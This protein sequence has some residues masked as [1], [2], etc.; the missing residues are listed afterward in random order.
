ME[1]NKKAFYAVTFSGHTFEIVV[2]DDKKM[3]IDDPKIGEKKVFYRITLNPRFVCLI[4]KDGERY[5]Y[6]GKSGPGTANELIC[7]YVIDKD[8]FEEL[9][10]NEMIRYSEDMYFLYGFNK[11]EPDDKKDYYLK[12]A[13]DYDHGV[14]SPFKHQKYKG[15]EYI[16]PYQKLGDFNGRHKKLAKIRKV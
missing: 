12:Q 5:T 4:K 9:K 8:L 6:K 14:H 16:L 15:E 13:S 1:E 2:R 3:E 10:Q 7:D 11:Y